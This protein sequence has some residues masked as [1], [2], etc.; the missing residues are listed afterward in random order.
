MDMP[1][2]FSTSIASNSNHQLRSETIDA[3]KDLSAGMTSNNDRH[4]SDVAMDVSLD[5]S[6][7]ITSKSAHQNRG[8]RSSIFVSRGNLTVEQESDDDRLRDVFQK[9]KRHISSSSF[10]DLCIYLYA[11]RAIIMTFLIHLCITMIIWGHFAIV[12]FGEQQMKVK[13]GAPNFWW[14][15][16]A[17]PL[18][19]GSMHAIL[20]QMSLIPLTM[21]RFTI[22]ALSH[23]LLNQYVPMNK[24]LAMHIHLGYVMISIVFIAV[25]FFFIFFG[26][27]CADGEQAFC[28]QMRT[29][30]MATGYAIL[31]TL[32]VIGGTSFYR[33]K[34]PYE[35]F[36]VI[37]HLV[38][39]MYLLAIIHT[40]DKVERT[41]ERDRSQTY[42]WFSSTL[43][44]YIADRSAMHLL[45]KHTSRLREFSRVVSS[46]GTR[47][48]TLTMERPNLLL[49]KPGQYVF[50]RVNSIDVHWHPFSIASSPTSESLEFYIEVFEDGTWTDKLWNT[51]DGA[52]KTGLT[53]EVMGPYGT[54]LTNPDEFT[55]GLAIGAG[56]GIVPI[57]SLYRQQI[58]VLSRLSPEA[59]LENIKQ[60]EAEIAKV[61]YDLAA[62]KGSFFQKFLNLLKKSKRKEDHL[63][64]DF[65]FQRTTDSLKRGNLHTK[66]KSHGGGEGYV[67]WREAKRNEREM[68]KLATKATSLLEGKLIEGLLTLL[69]VIS[70]GLTLSWN[71]LPTAISF[72]FTYHPVN[73]IYPGMIPFLKYYSVINHL[74]FTVFAIFIHNANKVIS[75]VDL[76]VGLII[77]FADWYFVNV[78]EVN[79]KLSNT[80][81]LLFGILTGYITLRWWTSMLRPHSSN[82]MSIS[83]EDNLTYLESLQ[84][85]WVTRSANL[86]ADIGPDIE[87]LWQHIIELWGRDNAEAVAPIKIYVTDTDETANYN[88]R[89]T[90]KG[91]DLLNS[92]SIFFER[93]NFG[94]IIED[95]SIRL[96]NSKDFSS[97]FLAFCGSPKLSDEL[98][99][100]KISNDLLMTMLGYKRHN[101]EY[102]SESYGGVKSAP[103]SNQFKVQG[104]LQRKNSTA[105]S[106][107]Q[108][109][110]EGEV[111]SL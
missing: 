14:K 52:E 1:L 54:S 10:T 5:L 68:N 18:E 93:P 85:I 25:I 66:I 32:L 74:M 28:I 58:D 16:I 13:P 84:I 55:H 34:I 26:K 71:L 50:L 78:Y 62:L 46:N 77:P 87:M 110:H 88:L 47:M 96:A 38:F 39:A 8:R 40:F 81:V 20:F 36:Y 17:P 83:K 79:G 51:L 111:L 6:T 53:F 11:K 70:L 33:Y 31:G 104:A 19:F 15:R 67:S 86:V 57:L 92:G 100:I 108:F 64:D 63:R 9:A 2:K 80:E 103:A 91:S 56:T 90:L 97:S 69:S 107:E 12:K 105:V 73:L 65:K 95:H 21:S 37:H 35:A 42:K 106:S 99:Q 30:I 61:I 72:K 45:H 109:T 76:I 48:I 22:T 75:F 98:S 41:D 49:F 23:S 60:H 29:E 7:G 4:I 101:M 102:H 89:E 59:H 43:L 44:Y 3:S 27:L 82:V 94:K 24:M